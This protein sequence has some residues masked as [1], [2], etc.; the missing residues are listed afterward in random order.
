MAGAR[1]F[2]VRPVQS[3]APFDLNLVFLLPAGHRVMEP[4]GKVFVVPF[5]IGY[6]RA[7]ISK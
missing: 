3:I 7:G 2:G 5:A 4:L 6:D 1:G